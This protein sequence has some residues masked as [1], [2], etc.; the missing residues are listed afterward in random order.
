[1]LPF[2]ARAIAHH[3]KIED[4]ARRTFT[5]EAFAFYPSAAIDLVS[6]AQNRK[7]YQKPMVRPRILQNLDDASISDVYSGD[8][9][10]APFLCHPTNH[11][12]PSYMSTENATRPTLLYEKRKLWVHRLY[13]SLSMH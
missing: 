4:V 9:S 7:S 2:S 3:C 8:D 1:M 13:S 12:S 11:S 5:K 6:H 10:S